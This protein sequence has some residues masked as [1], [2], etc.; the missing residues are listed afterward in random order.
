MR[1]R[2]SML[3]C[4]AAAA[5]MAVAPVLAVADSITVPKETDVKLIFDESLSSKTAKEG[6]MVKMHVAEDLVVD[7]KTVLKA[8]TPVTGTISKVEKRKR[9]G[10]NARMRFTLSPVKSAAGTMIPIEPR[11]KGKAAGSKTGEAAAA[12]GGGALLLGPVGLVGGYFVV[13][14]SVKIKPGDH[15]MS[16]VS[17]DTT[18][19]MK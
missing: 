6:Q 2:Y 19:N 16:T 8:G 1:R 13:G 17:S 11:E 18:V 14:K 5:S 15:L 4:L 12:S 10:V 3:A 9:F 7:G